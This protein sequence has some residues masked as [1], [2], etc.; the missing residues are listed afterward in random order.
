MGSQGHGRA[1]APPRVVLGGEGL[2]GS[3]CASQPPA[4]WLP[5]FCLSWAIGKGNM[6]LSGFFCLAFPPLGRGVPCACYGDPRTA[7]FLALTQVLRDHPWLEEATPQGSPQHESPCGT[8]LQVT[9]FVPGSS[10][11]LTLMAPALGSCGWF[12]PL[13]RADGSSPW[14]V[15]MARALG[16]RGWL[17]PLAHAD[18][19]SPW[20]N[21]MCA[22]MFA[23]T[24]AATTGRGEAGSS[25]ADEGPATKAARTS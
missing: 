5:S 8:R 10:S 24:G 11:L 20:L 2:T 21:L 1:C 22:P 6:K 14:L 17:E 7:K 4:V 3:P 16:S 15:L 9:E 25:G 13:A 18:G 12:E 19:S 23:P